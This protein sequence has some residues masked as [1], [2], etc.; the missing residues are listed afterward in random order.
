MID[1]TKKYEA[2]SRTL[3]HD[4]SIWVLY[5]D[6]VLKKHLRLPG[7]DFSRE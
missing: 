1:K 4:I 5:C 6:L 2:D 3:W 7:C